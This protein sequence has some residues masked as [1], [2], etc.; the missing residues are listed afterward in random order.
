MT[1]AE[2]QAVICDLMNFLEVG[3][4][5]DSL[6]LSDEI[7][8][9]TGI[10]MDGAAL[11]LFDDAPPIKVALIG[12]SYSADA[13]WQ[14]ADFLRLS[15]STQVMNLAETG[16]GPF[17]PMLDFLQDGIEAAPD[18]SVVIWEIP[19]RYLTRQEN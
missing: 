1:K 17:A 19:E 15:L 4:F 6:G 13:R 12:T 9:Q 2:N 18:I 8:P 16:Q 14:F 3:A 5:A 7:I 10:T 11:G